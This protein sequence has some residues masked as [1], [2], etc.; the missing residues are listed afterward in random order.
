MPSIVA[1]LAEAIGAR[2]VGDPATV[3]SRIASIEDAESDCLVFAQTAAAFARA[4]AT[5]AGAIIAGAFGDQ[6]ESGR[7]ILVVSDPR[8]AFARAARV[9]RPPA[10][11]HSGVHPAAVVAPT[12]TLGFGVTVGACAVIGEGVVV[13][14]RTTIGPGTVIQD[15]VRIG[16]DCRLVAN[17]VVYA[18]TTLGDRVVVHAGAVLGS[19]GFGYVR[20]S[21][22]GRHEPFP[23]VGGLEIEDDVEIGA[24][25]TID[26]GALGRTIIGAGT[27]LDNLVQIAH[28][29][30]V[31]R[32]VLMAAQCGVAGSSRV[33]DSAVLAGQV[34]VADHVH[35]ESGVVLCAQAGVPSKKTLYA[36]TKVYWGTPAR[37]IKAVIRELAWLARSVKRGGTGS[38]EP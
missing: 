12:V 28:N 1:H 18:G 13:G 23:Q 35:I 17:V 32:N 3:V 34:G 31:G 9:L 29:V 10:P 11:D 33:D 30:R 38:T 15:G 6:P 37:P 25:T 2:L 8:L 20:D 36:K 21:A 16:C 4:M 24:N 26:R 7:A 22:T 27:K 5:P 14:D 19:D